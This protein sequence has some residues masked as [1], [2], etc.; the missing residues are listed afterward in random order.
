MAISDDWTI[1]YSAKTIT[2][3][4]GTTIYT[5]R[6][7]YSWLMDDFDELTQ[8]D[9]SV[10]I[11]AQTPT[12][13]S[14]ING[15]DF[16]VPATD[17]RY[18][19]GGAI[20]R[21]SDDT[22]WANIY[23][24]GTIETGTTLYIEQNG[25]VLGGIGDPSYTSGHIDVL[26]KTKDAGSLIDS[27]NVTVLARELG[28]LY[29][30][31]PV[32][33]PSGRNAVPVATSPDTN[34]NETG[35]S[36]TGVTIGYA[37][38]VADVDDDASTEPYDTQVDC[39][40]N[41]LV[42]VYRYL[43]YLTRRGSTTSVDGVEGQ[44]YKIAGAGYTPVKQAPFGTFAG[45]V[46]FGARGVLLTN[47]AGAD[48]NSYILTD[49]NGVTRAPPATVGVAVNAIADQDRV[50]VFRLTGVAGSINSSEYTT[51]ASG[52]SSGSST[53]TVTTTISAD[54]PASGTIRL[55]ADGKRY[56]YASYTGSVFTL[57][58]TLAEDRNST[59]CF[60]PFLDAQSSAQTSLST[61]IKYQGSEIPVLVRVRQKG[62]LPFE[63]ESSITA[64]GM[65]VSAIR[66]TD[67]VVI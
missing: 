36:V 55:G 28:D 57:T 48:A 35:G 62:I 5:V 65:A 14:L 13:Y 60:V 24:L 12:E 56:P 52:N 38:Y 11:S 15:W 1:N 16:G 30:Y 34:D 44:I 20:T 40:G 53:V 23:T 59:N 63:V 39:G 61:S 7:F 18:L 21:T 4:S 2:H 22:V 43:K 3:S 46:F 8:L 67:G 9:D 45:G 64:A 27:G 51:A 19:K 26:V 6:A 58:G 17:I 42:N 66:T 32:S 25:A 33:A 47:M 41:T 31:F 50:A 29:D 49:S 37:G 54:T 10:P